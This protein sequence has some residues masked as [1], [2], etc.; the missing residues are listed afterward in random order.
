MKAR[1]TKDL[2][3]IRNTLSELQETIK[4]QL[5]GSTPFTS[6]LHVCSGSLLDA[7]DAMDRISAEI[8]RLAN[9]LEE[10]YYDE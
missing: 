5:Q 4:L 2:R 3:L 7:Q 1:T 10:A 8:E 9:E 6:D